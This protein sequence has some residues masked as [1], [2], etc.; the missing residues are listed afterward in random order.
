MVIQMTDTRRRRIVLFYAWGTSNLGD[1]AL[2]I[3]ALR[4][5]T[6][7]VPSEDILVVSRYSSAT[8]R[9]D[10]ASELSKLFPGVQIIHG[11]FARGRKGEA[12]GILDKCRDMAVA[13]GL[14][15]LPA[16]LSRRL[17][18]SRVATEVANA[19]LVLLNGGNLFYWHRTRRSLPRL[20]AFALPLVLAARNGVP[21]GLLPQ[22]CGPF[23]GW[24]PRWLGGLIEKAGFLLL[25]DSSSLRHIQTVARLDRTQYAL[26]PD[27]AFS[28]KGFVSEESDADA[29]LRVSDRRTIAVVLR[30]VPL[31]P[32]VPETADNPAE[33]VARINALV[34][35][36][37]AHLKKTI[38]ADIEIIIQAEDD[39]EVSRSVQSIL[40]RDYG[41]EATLVY[42]E[43]VSHLCAIY[44]RSLFVFSMRLHSMIFALSQ[45]TPVLALWRRQLGHKIPS[46]MEDLGLSRFC[47]ELTETSGKELCDAG[48]DLARNRDALAERID[49]EV[50]ERLKMLRDFLAPFCAARN[51]DEETVGVPASDVLG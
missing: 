7:L 46:M 37:L 50:N 6:S 13:A 19:T 51:Q 24:F 20:A 30:V 14:F 42:G 49:G 26:S 8:D 1:H 25:R 39:I 4:I 47:F 22:T 36:V 27:L 9:G 40:Q 33:T 45:N 48:L 21:Y 2:T 17:D 10:A 29:K 11:P 41:C 35:G 15:A 38:H 16:W 23:E 12:Y 3:G 18:P 5:L 31:G 43:S 44:S 28:L 34:P 32:D